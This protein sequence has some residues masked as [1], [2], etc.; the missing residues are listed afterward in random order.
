M[1]IRRVLLVPIAGTLLAGYLVSACGPA[2][3]MGTNPIT[4]QQITFPCNGNPVVPGGGG[5]DNHDDD[6]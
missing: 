2:Q 4:H 6:R 5:G 3:C 1:K